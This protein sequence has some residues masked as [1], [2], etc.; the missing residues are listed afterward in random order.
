MTAPQKILVIDDDDHI[1]EIIASAAHAMGFQCQATTDP[2]IF[3][4]AVNPDT[5]LVLIDL[6]MPNVDGVQLLRLL[7]QQQCRAPIVLMSGIGKRVIETAEQLGSVHGLSIVG[8][9][10]KPFRLRELEGL[11]R[12]HTA[13]ELAI[14]IPLQTISPPDHDLRYAIEHNQFVVH[15][16]P[17]VDIASRAVVG[18]E[19]LA[20]WN[21]PGHGIIPP[22]DFITRLESLGL[23]DQLGWLIAHQALS[24]FP[25]FA[26]HHGILPTL[27]LNVSAYSLRNLDYPDIFLSL[28]SKYGV[29]PDR[30]ILEI[31]ESGLIKELASS[32]DVLTRLRLKQVQLAID[33]FGTGFS[34]MRQLRNI[35][36]NELKIDR[37][38]VQHLESSETDRTMVRKTIEMGH[39]LNLK[40]IAEGVETPWQLDFLHTHHC[41]LAQGELFSQPLPA[42]ELIDWL[43]NYRA[44]RAAIPV[45]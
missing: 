26:D 23:I 5:T 41:D 22:D 21:H 3:L 28:T 13:P 45:I 12:A 33:D 42:A 32:L 43:K 10:H 37:S 9:L 35:P 18:L 17:E 31:T 36:A 29:P 20:R 6:L 39:S 40:V 44:T 24:Q 2:A 27:S 30:I 38:F 4:A 8:H 34:M 16:Q 19:A 1:G 11:L 25:R 14:P 15:F 7:G